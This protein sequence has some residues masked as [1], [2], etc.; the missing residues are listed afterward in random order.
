M[1]IRQ[2]VALARMKRGF[3]DK[4]FVLFFRRRINRFISLHLNLAQQSMVISN[5]TVHELDGQFKK[6]LYS[7]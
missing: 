3:L 1:N 4:M 6:D 2:R 7:K 5:D